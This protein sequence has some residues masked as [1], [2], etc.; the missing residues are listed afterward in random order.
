MD[1]SPR[2]PLL[3]EMGSQ[4]P[5]LGM[6]RTKTDIFFDGTLGKKPIR[7]VPFNHPI[8]PLDQEE[9]KHELDNRPEEAQVSDWRS[10]VGSR[11]VDANSDGQVFNITL[12]DVPERENDLTVGR[13]IV[14]TLEGVTL[15][16]NVTDMLG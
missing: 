6:T 10:M 14:E 4:T 2:P 15:A 11:M 9:E 12:A 8:T 16:V 5:P 1:L 13:Y 3:K 7:I